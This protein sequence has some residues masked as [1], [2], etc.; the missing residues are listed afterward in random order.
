MHILT[1]PSTSKGEAKVVPGLGV[2]INYHYYWSPVMKD[3]RVEGSQV[4]VRYDPFDLTIAYACVGGI[5]AKCVGRLPDYLHGVSE[6]V[7]RLATAEVKK[8]RAL[9]GLGRKELAR[10][11]ALFVESLIEREDILKQRLKD[12]D[13]RTVY[14]SRSRAGRA[15]FTTAEAVDPPERETAQPPRRIRTR[16]IEEM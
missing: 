2:I 14:A 4:P 15:A 1:C 13:E 6:R 5:W 7:L 10:Q 12:E 8:Q 11:R 16:K 3:S 9:R